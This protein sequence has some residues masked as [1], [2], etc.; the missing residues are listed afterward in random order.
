[1]RAHLPWTQPALAVGQLLQ[2]RTQLRKETRRF[3]CCSSPCW[4]GLGTWAA[5][6]GRELGLGSV[7]ST[8]GHPP[9]AGMQRFSRARRCSTGMSHSCSAH[10]GCPTPGC[11]KA[12]L[13]IWDVPSC[14]PHLGCS[15]LLSAALLGQASTLPSS[16]P[17]KCRTKCSEAS[18]G[19]VLGVW[20]HL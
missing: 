3:G 1:M 2:V 18:R 9:R 10:L 8:A 7:L 5:A 15:Q 20:L 14:S 4:H 11:P 19:A 12:A 13:H 16:A 6:L 17:E